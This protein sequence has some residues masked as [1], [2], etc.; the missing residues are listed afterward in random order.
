MPDLT[1]NGRPV[2]ERDGA[3]LLDV[4]AEALGRRLAPDG[5]PE[6]GGR[7]GAAAAV[8][9]AVVPRSRWS[10]TGLADGQSVEVITAVQGG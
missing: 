10:R 1:L 2:S 7:I 6:D 3:T 8:D 5:S 9:G 4:V